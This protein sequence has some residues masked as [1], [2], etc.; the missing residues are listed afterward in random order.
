MHLFPMQ[1]PSAIMPCFHKA[2]QEIVHLYLPCNS[3]GLHKGLEGGVGVGVSENK[4]YLLH[5]YDC[6]CEQR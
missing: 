1:F 5:M 2:K 4:M 6:T 3:Q